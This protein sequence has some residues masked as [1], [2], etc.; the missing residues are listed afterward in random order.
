MPPHEQGFKVLGVPFGHPEFVKKFLQNK[1]SEHKVLL[2]RIPA[3]Q[4]TQSA[5][6]LLS[7][8]AAA[9][10]NFF[11]RAVSPQ[12]TQEFAQAHDEGVWQCLCR[13]LSV[14]VDCGAQEQSSLPWWE[15]GIGLRSACRTAPAAHWASWADA[16]KMIRDRHPA[17]VD[18]VVDALRR[19]EES[20]TIRT[21]VE[22]AAVL[23]RTGF[24]CP[25]WED[26]AEGR[27]PGESRE[28]EDPSQP[29]VGWQQQAAT[30]IEHHDNTVWPGLREHEQAMMR[31]Q[32]GPLASTAFTCFP[33]S[34]M[35][36]IDP[37]PFCALLLRR[38][39]LPLPLSV[40]SCR[41]GR[42]LDA[43]GHHRAACATAGV[44]GRRGWALE[45]VAARVC[46]EG[47]ASSTGPTQGG[48]RWWQMASPCMEERS[49]QLTQWRRRIG[50]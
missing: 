15:G 25:S 40:R 11:L 42:P 13:I 24:E 27:S 33:T 36:R 34:R 39:R 46:R 7:F 49:L 4:D 8:C 47:G 37:A 16:L 29:R 6:L 12:F 17:V 1:N 18:I 21:V 45:S 50:T 35:T 19:P 22:C 3:I 41:C 44:L 30:S 31:S 14:H 10:S 32:R 5:W 26:L 2:D 20:M 28:E 38:L 48:W 43:L 23:E 9:R